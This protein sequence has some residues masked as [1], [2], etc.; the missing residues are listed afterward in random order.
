M[1]HFDGL[2]RGFLA[3]D[4]ADGMLKF[5]RESRGSHQIRPEAARIFLAS[6]E[7]QRSLSPDERAAIPLFL[8][9]P[10]PPIYEWMLMLERIGLDPVAS[11]GEEVAHLRE[12]RHNLPK[13]EA[14][15]KKMFS[16][17]GSP[18]ANMWWP[19]TSIEKKPIATVERAIAA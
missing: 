8:T 7:M 18:T 12:L 13:I 5:G 11:L 14:I 1:S 3:Q 2:S 15:M 17:A 10:C 16:P 4:I 6:Y 19:Q 9:I